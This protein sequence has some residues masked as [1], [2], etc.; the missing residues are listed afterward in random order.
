MKNY[1]AGQQ[2]ADGR[3]ALEAFAEDNAKHIRSRLELAE[4][5]HSGDGEISRGL[6]SYTY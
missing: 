6:D 1:F 3:N 4:M 2:L 5:V